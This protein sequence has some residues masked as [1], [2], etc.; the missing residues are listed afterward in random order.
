MV[1][2]V[3]GEAVTQVM[4]NAIKGTVNSFAFD[5]NTGKITVLVDYTD[6]DG[7]SQQR[8]FSQDELVPTPVTE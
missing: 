2:F 4:P 5:P 3:Q 1:A 6:A 8:Y 7:N